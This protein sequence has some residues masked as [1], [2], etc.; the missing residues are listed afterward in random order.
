MEAR[1]S[2]RHEARH[3]SVLPAAM[4]ERF[5]LLCVSEDIGSARAILVAALK[6]AGFEVD[7]VEVNL[8]RP[9]DV[10]ARPYRA[11]VF[12]INKSDGAGYVLL[13][14]IRERSILPIMLVLHGVARNDVLLGFQAGADAYMLAPFDEREF[15]A[16]MRGLVQRI[17]VQRPVV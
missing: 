14:R 13:R 11:I 6:R 9:P 17:P 8:H 2:E 4:F 15:Q 7:L 16:R 10:Q 1:Q 12:D 3:P 5:V